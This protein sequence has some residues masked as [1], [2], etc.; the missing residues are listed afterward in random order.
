[1]IYIVVVSLFLIVFHWLNELDNK[2][3]SLTKIMISHL[4]EGIADV[5][6]EVDYDI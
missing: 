1:M 6:S 2:I 3:Q 4:F 5:H